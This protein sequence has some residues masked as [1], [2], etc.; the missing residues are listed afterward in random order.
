MTALGFGRANQEIQSKAKQKNHT[1]RGKNARELSAILKTRNNTD[2]LKKLEPLLKVYAQSG[3]TNPDIF[4]ALL[5]IA[6]AEGNKSDAELWGNEW[7]KYPSND[8]KELWNQLRRSR[9]LNDNSAQIKLVTSLYKKQ[10]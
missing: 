6:E 2:K 1:Q 7:V 10:K 9:L 4:K 3:T 5:E 8:E